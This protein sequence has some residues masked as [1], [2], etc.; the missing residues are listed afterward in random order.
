MSDICLEQN[1]LLRLKSFT[2]FLKQ[3]SVVQVVSK[4]YKVGQEESPLILIEIISSSEYKSENESSTGSSLLPLYISSPP[5]LSPPLSLPSPID[6]SLFY[7]N[8]SQ[9]NINQL[10]KQIRVQQEQIVALQAI[11]TEERRVVAELNVE[12]AKL[13]VFS[14]EASKVREFIIA[15]RLYLRMRIR[16]IIV[17]EQ[18]LQILL[19]VQGGSADVWK[20][21][22]LKDLESG[23]VEYELAG[24]FLL[25]LKKEF[26]EGDEELV[27]VAE[28]RRI[29]QEERTIE[30][31]V[32]EFWRVARNSGYKERI[33][34]KEFKRGMNGT[35]RK[36]LMEA[37]RSSTSIEQQHEYVTNLDHYWRE[38]RKEKKRLR[39]RKENENQE[40]R[41]QMGAT[42]IQGEFRP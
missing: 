39:E 3:Q 27:K 40:Q 28:L 32:Q 37:E 2:S 14:E 24:E 38:R 20:E 12:V 9:L 30:E 35:I 23:E 11:I 36:K 42:N 26:G 8:M 18:I 25:E 16:G 21:N 5:T 34:V 10:L 13:P 17:K 41:Q 29:E 1:N 6:F 22:L 31:F 7:N 33:L 19:Y 4:K 15:C